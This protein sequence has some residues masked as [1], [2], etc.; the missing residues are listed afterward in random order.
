M[1]KLKKLVGDSPLSSAVLGDIYLV[2]ITGALFLLMFNLMLPFATTLLIALLIAALIQPIFKGIAKIL[3]K[4]FAAL[5]CMLLVLFVI[6]LPITFL[7]IIVIDE[8]STFSQAL[9]EQFSS[10]EGDINTPEILDLVEMQVQSVNEF[11]QDQGAQINIEEQV[12]A[13]LSDL[14]NRLSNVVL[15]LFSGLGSTLIQL[16]TFLIALFLFTRDFDQ[17]PGVVRRY[18]PLN[19]DLEDLLLKEFLVTGKSLLRGIFF[20]GAIHAVLMTIVFWLFGLEALGILMALVFLTSLIPGGSQI[21]WIPT[22]IVS[23]ILMGPTIGLGLAVVSFFVMNGIDTVVRPALTRGSV[24]LHPL[25]SFIAL[26]GGLVVYGL[27]GILYGPLI[28][29]MFVTI[30]RAYNARFKPDTTK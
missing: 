25:L 13:T 12:L 1:T 30:V 27:G 21:V 18:I 16:I 3:N 8:V 19:D 14:G 5:I 4:N 9:S 26:L 7:S 15:S 22:A 6:I 2:L 17:L 28:A 11:F 29:V 20:V 10:E 23:G 24:K